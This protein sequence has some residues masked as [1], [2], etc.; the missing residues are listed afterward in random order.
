[1]R[2]GQYTDSDSTRTAGTAPTDST[3]TADAAGTDPWTAVATDS[4]V[5]DLATAGAAAGVDIGPKTID[6]LADWEWRRKADLAVEYA[7]STGVGV[8]REPPVLLGD[9][10]TATVGV[11]SVGELT[12]EFQTE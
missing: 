4:G 8:Y 11:E 1:M 6:L 5:V 2:I 7:K 12:T 9:G 10:D 3:S